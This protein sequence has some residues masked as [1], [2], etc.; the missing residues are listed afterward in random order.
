MRKQKEILQTIFDRVPAMITLQDQGGHIMLANRE[1]EEKLGW[2]L[3]EITSQDLDLFAEMYPDPQVRQAVLDFIGRADGRW[4]DFKTR[5]KDGRVIDTSWAKVRLS[6]GIILGVGK[7]ITE[8]KQAEKALRES[9]NKLKEAQQLAHIGYWE[10]DHIADRITLSEGACRILGLQPEKGI[11]SQAKLQEMIHPDDR[12]IKQQALTEALQGSQLYDVEYRIVRSDGD[13]RFVHVCDEIEYDGSGRPARMFGAVQ[14]ITERKQAEEEIRRNAARME[15]LAGISHTFQKAGLDYQSVLDTV[16]RRTAE[17]IGDACVMTLFSD[18]GQR[19][20]LVSF[21]H[22]DL[23]ARAMMHDAI[24]QTWQGGTDIRDHP[25]YQTLLA[26]K[27]I[28]IPGAN[29]EEFQASLEPEFQ[30][31]FDAVGISSYI[32]VPLKVQGRVIG[33]LGLTRDRQGAAYTPDDQVLLQDLADRAALTIQNARLFEQVQ[34]A[35]QRLQAL[36]SQLLVVREV[37]MRAIAREL[38]D[39]VGQILSG[40]IMQLGTAK[41][42]LPKSAKSV[43][44]ILEQSEELI[45]Q[46]LERT[47]HI[48]AGLRPQVL[49]DL[50]LAPA[51][52]RLVDEFQQN[53]G[54]TVEFTTGSFPKRLPPPVEVALFRIVQ[55]GL[56]NVR[57]HAQARQVSILLAKEA[58][59][60]VLSVQDDGLGL[61]K[62]PPGPH[63]NGDLILDGGWRIPEGHYGL[64][65]IQERVA[66][67]GGKLQITSAPGQGTT[68]RVELPLVEKLLSEAGAGSDERQ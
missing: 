31:L 50:G 5:T 22:R 27:S 23:K 52:R 16:A 66:Q 18:D 17:L 15:M 65:G 26:G 49:D 67:L 53:T 24:L 39:E 11:L 29:P 20:Y 61:E 68:L 41:S 25:R 48:I 60:V 34:G 58:G 56:T 55:E 42:L 37:E 4:E 35:R 46:T 30:D 38:H 36:S 62:Q 57:K 44:N 1:F 45:D 19:S 3:E 64:I 2:R 12:Q 43:Q 28:F 33:A 14:D 63:A 47:R 21:Y 8:R 6:D 10:C 32:F 51:L 13:I 59:Q 7:D 54:I 40:L 9:E